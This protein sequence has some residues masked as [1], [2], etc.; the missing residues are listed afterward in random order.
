MIFLNGGDSES[1]AELIEK[2]KALKAEGKT[3]R[4]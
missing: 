3:I 1:E 4:Q 2:V